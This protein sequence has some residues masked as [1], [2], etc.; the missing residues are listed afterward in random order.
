MSYIQAWQPQDH[1]FISCRY[2]RQDLRYSENLFTRPMDDSTLIYWQI[3]VGQ[4]FIKHY[5]AFFGVAC[6]WL[7]TLFNICEHVMVTCIIIKLI[8]L[9]EYLFFLKEH[10]IYQLFINIGMQH[11]AINFKIHC[12]I[13]SIIVL[14]TS[15]LQV[16]RPN[17]WFGL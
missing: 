5:S 12:T 9:C 17:F 2:H 1:W 11:Y 7:S 3:I 13:I 10:D 15:V 16:A 6:I 4:C 14:H 8:G